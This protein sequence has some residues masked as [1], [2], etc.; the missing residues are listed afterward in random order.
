MTQ[1]SIVRIRRMSSLMTSQEYWIA[2]LVDPDGSLLWPDCF[3]T[4]MIGPDEARQ[5]LMDSMDAKVESPYS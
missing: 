2:D 5:A 4:S 1:S 3:G